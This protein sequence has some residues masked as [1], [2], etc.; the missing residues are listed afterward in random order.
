MLTWLLGNKTICLNIRYLITVIGMEQESVNDINWPRT[1]LT[2]G[3]IHRRCVIK[4]V[5]TQMIK[6]W[7]DHFPLQS[8]V[9]SH[10]TISHYVFYHLYRTL[11]LSIE[12]H[13][14]LLNKPVQQNL[15]SQL[16]G[17]PLAKQTICYMT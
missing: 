4:V 7:M 10:Y 13:S 14:S 15:S 6:D 11:E 8:H 3:A 12:A 2:L 9:V 1:P 16:K 5:S 17:P